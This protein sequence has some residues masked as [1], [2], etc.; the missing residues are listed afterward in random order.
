MDLYD[1]L[2]DHEDKVE[3][4]FKI[5]R[6]AD[7]NVAI[8]AFDRGLKQLEANP[9]NQE[10]AWKKAL[11]LALEKAQG[12]LVTVPR[13]EQKIKCYDIMCI[14]FLALQD[15]N[16]ASVAILHETTRLLEDEVIKSSLSV[17]KGTLRA[18]A[19]GALNK[20]DAKVLEMLFKSVCGAIEVCAKS[21]QWSSNNHRRGFRD[22]FRNNRYIYESTSPSLFQKWETLQE[23]KSGGFFRIIPRKVSSDIIMFRDILTDLSQ[24]NVSDVYPLGSI[25][26][27]KDG[28][29][30]KFVPGNGTC[31][32]FPKRNLVFILLFGLILTIPVMKSRWP[33]SPP[34]SKYYSFHLML[35]NYFD[36]QKNIES[37]LQNLLQEETKN[38]LFKSA[39]KS[40]EVS[41]TTWRTTVAET[42][43]ICIQTMDAKLRSAAVAVLLVAKNSIFGVIPD[44][45]RQVVD[46]L[47]DSKSWSIE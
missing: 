30:F 44:V 1:K 4:H 26:M 23:F 40:K 8:N 28:A 20:T 45:R 25:K 41:G 33:P 2:L 16:D 29:S 31:G 5:L 3:E 47:Y 21:K 22:L 32:G 15:E 38:N 24:V 34:T 36:R 11:E 12:G 14:C 17:L 35:F 42:S 10:G 43:K 39:I 9:N 37:N 6:E 46:S 18:R 27:V 13:P 7:M 19:G